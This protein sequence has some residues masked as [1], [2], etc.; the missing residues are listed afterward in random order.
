MTKLDEQQKMIYDDLSMPEKVAILLIQLG[1]D[2]T[3][4][5]FS[6]M[7]ID[8]ITEISR[9]IAS[10][11]T[12]D[13]TVAAAVLEE[14]YALMQSNQYMK[15]GGIEYAKEILFRTFG[16]EIA[17]KIMDKLQKSMETTKSFG[18]LSQ[19]R[20]Q[21]LA[22]FIMKEHPQ[23]IALIVAHM[24]ATSAAETLV[25]FPDEL[26]SE[27]IIRM[28]NLGDI[29]PSVVK[30]V[31]TVLESKL[32]S[33]TSYKV[34]VGG[35]RAVAEVL[36]RLGQ[37]ASKSTIG[38]IE[39]TDA[40]L[41]TTIKEMM[42]TFEDINTLDNN[43][44]REILKVVDKKD[45]MIGLKGS[46]EELKQKFLSNMSQRA[47][48]AFV[49]EMQFLGAVRV[50]DVEEAQRRVVEMVQKLSEEGIFQVGESDEMIE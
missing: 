48:E 2:A 29:S 6:H 9:Y 40:T 14:F 35:P 18:Y 30:R 27:V 43:A 16:P 21:Q 15:S 36:N 44:I 33:L 1:E 50:K 39:Q 5:I 49:E 17:Q 3:T 13:K 12:I 11:K 25:Y 4:L 41:A 7:D 23:T 47:S 26:R 28:A 46:G 31:S 34:E 38:I 22:D 19:V 24:D 37:K 45:L 32:E 10:A 8:V 42:F 20:P